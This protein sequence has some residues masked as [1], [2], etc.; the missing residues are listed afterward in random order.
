[1]DKINYDEADLLAIESGAAANG[2]RLTRGSQSSLR[3]S[4]IM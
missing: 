3:E 4:L 1:M 2:I